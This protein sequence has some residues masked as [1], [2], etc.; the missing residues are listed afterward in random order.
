MSLENI[1]NLIKNQNISWENINKTLKENNAD[2]ETIDQALSVFKK[3]DKNNDNTISADEWDLA[4]KY[5][6]KAD[7]NQDG[8]LNDTELSA[9]EEGNVF[10]TS[11]AKVTNTFLNAMSNSTI[12]SVKSTSEGVSEGGGAML[13]I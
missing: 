1:K 11:G 8:K 4:D 9:L 12:I 2:Q 10:R 13:L 7:T 6:R 3:L 5:L